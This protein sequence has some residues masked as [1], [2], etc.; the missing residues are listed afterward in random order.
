MK[1]Q[2]I[3]LGM[4]DQSH[5]KFY[6]TQDMGL[7]RA[8]SG[9]GHEVDLY[10]FV[11]GDTDETIEFNDHLRMHYLHSPSRGFHSM[12][13]CEFITRDVDAVIVF[14]DNQMNFKRVAQLCREREVVCLPYVGA[15]GSHNPS[16]LK[17]KLLDIAIPNVRYYRNM[18]VLAKTPDV[19]RQMEEQGI[20]DVLLAP[21]CLDLYAVNRDY[22]EASPAEL[23]ALAGIPEGAKVLLYIARLT[24]EKHPMEMLDIF[25]RLKKEDSAYYMISIGKGELQAA[26]EKRIAEYGLTDSVKRIGYIE[27]SRMWEFY[28]M[29]DVLVNLNR[30]EIFGMAIL[31]AMYYECPVAARRAPGPE[32]ILEQK[33]DGILCKNTEE[34]IDAVKA[35]CGDEKLRGTIA[36]AAHNKIMERFVWQST[37]QII[38]DAIGQAERGIAEQGIQDGK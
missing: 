31:E 28:R 38:L 2:I 29:S 13:S 33:K 6:N 20:K 4:T 9:M 17:K 35:L 15:L 30:V 19:K 21:C 25:R 24:D 22:R 1:I 18:R 34:I 14:S 32:Y 36:K 3:A 26:F 23:K 12:H 27:N 8:L 37:A 11:R 16:R 10:S 7:G 5:R